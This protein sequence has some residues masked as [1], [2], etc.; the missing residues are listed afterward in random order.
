MFAVNAFSAKFTL[1]MQGLAGSR[2]M[3]LGTTRHMTNSAQNKLGTENSAHNTQPITEEL[4]GPNCTNYELRF[5]K[6][7]YTIKILYS[8][9]H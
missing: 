5:N 8:Q 2:L 7:M 6:F 1:F 9:S 3:D 4:I